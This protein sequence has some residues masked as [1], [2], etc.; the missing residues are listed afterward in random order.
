MAA[1]LPRR[2]GRM[3]KGTAATLPL[4]SMGPGGPATSLRIRESGRD[5]SP[6]SGCR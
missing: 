5:R 4:S 3:D 6:S 2:K 1:N